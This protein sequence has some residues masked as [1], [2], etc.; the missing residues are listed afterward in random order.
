LLN[1]LAAFYLTATEIFFSQIF[2]R[3]SENMA[4]T[5]KMHPRFSFLPLRIKPADF[6]IPL[7]GFII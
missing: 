4:V 1:C 3:A 2:T 7:S 5:Q 6:R